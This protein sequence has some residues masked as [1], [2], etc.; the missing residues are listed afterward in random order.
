MKA[1]VYLRRN[2]KKLAGAVASGNMNLAITNILTF[3]RHILTNDGCHWQKY[4]AGEFL[5]APV[6]RGLYIYVYNYVIQIFEMV[7][8]ALLLLLEQ[9]PQLCSRGRRAV[10]HQEPSRTNIIRSDGQAPESS[11]QSFPT[12]GTGENGDCIEAGSS[13]R[14]LLRPNDWGRENLGVASLLPS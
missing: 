7:V 2:L 11:R 4:S 13:S 12:L 8:T 14:I 5:L 1:R 6:Y 3:S 9:H 10:H